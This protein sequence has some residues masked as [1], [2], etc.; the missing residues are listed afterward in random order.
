MISADILPEGTDTVVSVVYGLTPL[1]GQVQE[2]VTNSPVPGEAGLTVIDAGLTG[3]LPYKRYFYQI[4]AVNSLG[5]TRSPIQ[6]IETLQPPELVDGN[7]AVQYDADYNKNVIVSDVLVELRDKKYDC[8]LAPETCPDVEL[9][10]ST[11]WTLGAGI[12]ISDG[13]LRFTDVANNLNAY[14]VIPALERVTG[15]WQVQMINVAERNGGLRILLGGATNQH[16]GV[17][18][19]TIPDGD[20]IKD[21]TVSSMNGIFYI[22]TVTPNPTSGTIDSISVRRI[23]GSHAFIGTANQRPVKTL[24]NNYFQF[25]GLN[26]RLLAGNIPTVGTIYAKARRQ[27]ID[28]DFIMLNDLTGIGEHTTTTLTL[29]ANSAVSTFYNVSII[30]L[31]IRTVVDNAETIAKLNEWFSRDSYEIPPIGG[32]LESNFYN[33]AANWDDAAIVFLY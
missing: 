11:G 1:L 12:T 28:A 10:S 21:V 25:D 23:L 27:G 24:L 5:V 15:I 31:V 7:W 3:L 18:S 17:D 8:A 9:N 22:R 16:A 20:F 13:K 29:G 4:E 19:L 2:N 14:F 26:D 6:Y 33:D 32:V 30:R